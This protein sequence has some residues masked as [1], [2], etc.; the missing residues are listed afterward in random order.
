MDERIDL[1]DV[2]KRLEDAFQG[3]VRLVFWE[4]EGSDYAEA[5]ESIQ[6]EGATILNA[7]H[8]EM[9]VKRRVL[10]QEPEGRFV[11]YRSGGAP[12]PYTDLIL[13]LKL[14][15]RPFVCSMEGMWAEEC[16]IP[17]E[18]ASTISDHAAFFKS[19]ER[20][21]MLAK[22]G[23]L[24]DT[25]E[26]LRFALC[27]VTLR[28][29]DSIARDA[30]RS[31]AARAII[32][33]SREDEVALRAISA[34][35]LAQTFWSAMR[36]HL[37]YAPS[38][39]S[40][41]SVGDMAFRML[42]G[43][44]GDIVDDE[45]KA[46]PAESSKVLGDLARTVQ[47]RPVFDYVVHEYEDA[48]AAAIPEDARTPE[49]LADVD[50]IPQIDQ[51][52]L[53]FFLNAEMESGLD[54]T[55]LENVWARRQYMLFAVRY[56]HHYEA[57]IALARFE[58][59]YNDYRGSCG[60]AEGL[61]GL[62]SSYAGSWHEV[63]RRYREFFL[64]CKRMGETRFRK[65]L[66]PAE[67]KMLKSYDE[68][69][70]D[71][72]NRW[73]THLMDEGGWPPASVPSQDG[74]FHDRV[75]LA[76]PQAD[77]SNRLAVIISDALRYEAGKDLAE[78]LS[79]SKAAGL[80][81]KISVSCDAAVCMLPSYTQLGMAA[82][83]P[84]GT[85]EIDPA[86]CRVLKDGK[87]TDGLQNRGTLIASAVEGARAL[88]AEKML[89]KGSVNLED[90]PL[91]FVYHNVIDKTGDARDSE[92]RTFEAVDDACD[93]IEKLVQI[94]LR[95]GCGK[96]IVT[97]DHGFLYQQQEPES[98]AYS[99]VPELSKTVA[100]Q[101]DA[102]RSRRFAVGA[103]L[104]EDS[105]LLSFQAKTLSLKGDYEVVMPRGITRLRL[106][107]SGARFVHGGASAQEDVIPIVTV[108]ATGAHEEATQPTGV[109][110]FT[111]G[112][113]VITGPSVS[114]YVYQTKP[115]GSGVSPLTVRVGVY[116][117]DKEGTLLCTHERELELSSTSD[118]PEQRKTRV[119]LRLTDEVDDHPSAWLRISAKVGS[120][121]RYQTAWQKEYSVNRAFGSDF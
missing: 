84:A 26:S 43:M 105:S 11:L 62:L 35:G 27:A 94:L 55:L 12:D 107:G 8:H 31:M 53:M 13:D 83:L 110:G 100:G 4:D 117:K 120:T 75:E 76:F 89:E 85:L 111:T 109:E 97:A 77:R 33:W 19:K 95:A 29:S 5:I 18:L 87:P 101:A 34:A 39:G 9:A 68:F 37:G 90:V 82:L 14:Q 32:E 2:K 44:C 69:L 66:K 72:T 78:R 96:V 112:R 99:D 71:L 103:G 116:D 70:S 114:V 7:T 36:E 91:A 58:R 48:V 54:L 74:F 59:A 61:A 64:A 38:A 73:Q 40:E 10:R 42:E 121:T 22:S 49:L 80:A 88:S 16:G 93:E 20:R 50:A 47:R 21:Q 86:S 63:D 23:L 17:V 115:C 25:V 24:K 108:E 52:I 28:S 60:N 113:P 98:Y 30:A 65:A 6:L 57:L 1:A 119:T 67:A 102:A 92:G 45:G 104:P 81:G 79:A 41:P 15:A 51:W 3:N 106:Q 46:D 118:D 56:R